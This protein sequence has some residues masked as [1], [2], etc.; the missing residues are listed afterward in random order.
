[1]IF[2]VISTRGVNT[3]SL[4]AVSLFPAR[5]GETKSMFTVERLSGA[6]AL[7][8][9]VSQ[10]ASMPGIW[11]ERLLDGER[12]ERLSLDARSRQASPAALR[13]P[14]GWGSPPVVLN[15]GSGRRQQPVA[16]CKACFR[17]RSGVDSRSPR[18]W[19]KGPADRSARRRDQ[20]PPWP[21]TA[22]KTWPVE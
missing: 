22:A 20:G 3:M 13:P 6:P 12:V 17:A 16:T 8:V 18:R 7:S 11:S 15:H 14:T 19:P 21:P 5:R 1:M 9:P 4:S 2:F 10:P